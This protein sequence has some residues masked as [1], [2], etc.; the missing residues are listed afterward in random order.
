MVAVT[1]AVMTTMMMTAATMTK[2]FESKRSGQGGFSLLE[3]IFALVIIIVGVSAVLGLIVSAVHLHSFSRHSNA[4]GSVAKAKI[5]EL[6]NYDPGA[7]ER[8]RGGSTTSDASGYFDFPDPRFKRR[9]LIEEY[10]TDA[11]VPQGTKRITVSVISNRGD[12]SI[13]TVEV[14][15]LVVD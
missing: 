9:W 2:R 14:V 6:R 12:V 11:G 1:A 10:P 7:T 3:C 13:P 4:A 8:N 15:V 5:E